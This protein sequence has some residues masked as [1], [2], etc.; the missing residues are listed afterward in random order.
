[1]VLASATAARRLAATRRSLPHP[2]CAPRTAQ[3]DEATQCRAEGPVGKGGTS[4]APG[5]GPEPDFQRASHP[6]LKRSGDA[7]H[8]GPRGPRRPIV[9]DAGGQET[10]HDQSRSNY[11]SIRRAP[12]FARVGPSSGARRVHG[13][14][15][16]IDIRGRKVWVQHDGTSRPVFGRGRRDDHVRSVSALAWGII[17]QGMNGTRISVS[18]HPSICYVEKTRFI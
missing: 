2:L 10:D 1:M 4:T 3:P 13:C 11:G 5:Q 17:P 12:C 15:S 7:S 8:A 16:H 18:S 6:G 14:V 9:S